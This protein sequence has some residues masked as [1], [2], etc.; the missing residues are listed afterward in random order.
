MRRAKIV[1][2]V[3][4]CTLAFTGCATVGGGSPLTALLDREDIAQAL[5]L[6]NAVDPATD[7]GAPYRARCYATLLKA[8]PEKA[9]QPPAPEIKGIVSGFE[10][11]AELVAKRRNAP[12]TGLVSE[13]VQADCGYLLDEVKR[14][15]IRNGAKLFPG[16]GAVGGLIAR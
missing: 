6:A 14:F 10:V 16:G 13:A 7:P 4:A 5:T 8:I 12:N 2:V 15:A 9:A 1:A 11:A 3:L